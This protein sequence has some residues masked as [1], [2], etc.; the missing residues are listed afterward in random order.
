MSN[1]SRKAPEGKARS[2]A[3]VAAAFQASGTKY[4]VADWTNHDPVIA[5]A[6]ADQGRIGVPLYLVYDAAGDAPKVLPQLLTPALVVD[7]LR[8]AAAKPVAAPASNG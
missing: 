1:R 3:Q 6:L 5:R 7:A 2:S 4:M 8:G